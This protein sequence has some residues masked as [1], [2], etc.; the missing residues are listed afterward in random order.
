MEVLGL[1][2]YRTTS[3][4]DRGFLQNFS[5]PTG[6]CWFC[7]SIST[8]LLPS[9]SFPVHDF[10]LIRR[11]TVYLVPS[12]WNE[13]QRTTNIP[14]AHENAFR[15]PRSWQSAP[16]N[17]DA[18]RTDNIWGVL[19]LCTWTWIKLVVHTHELCTG[20]TFSYLHK[21]LIYKE[22]RRSVVS[23]GITLR[24]GRARV[25][26]PIRLLDFSFDLILPAALWLWGRLSL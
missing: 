12:L 6:T 2:N 5:F 26:F 10:S 19:L 25:R 24:A 20:V 14:S 7:I 21:Y 1:N 17:T 23:W 13:A 4:T 9:K 8:R 3:C 11:Y 22:A 15:P 18:K 16:R